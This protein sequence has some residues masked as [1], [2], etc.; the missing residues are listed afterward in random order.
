MSNIA[1]FHKVEDLSRPECTLSS[2]EEV[3]IKG[4]IFKVDYFPFYPGQT[5]Q[6]VVLQFVGENKSK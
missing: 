1:T 2:G 4:M 5:T 3:I 6:R